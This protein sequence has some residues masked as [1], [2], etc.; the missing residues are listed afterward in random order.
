[1]KYITRSVWILSIVSLFTDMASEM[2]YP[3]MPIY[4]KSI[5]FSIVLIGI[6]EG[7]AEATAGLSKGYFGKRSDVAGRRVPFVQLG[8]AFSAISKPMMA[9]FVYPLWIFLARTVDRF[10]KGIRTGA[11]DALLS[12]EATPQTKGKVF[13]FHRSMDTLGA[14]IGPALALL[15]LYYNPEDYKT[16]FL[17]AFIPGLLAV[18]ATFF[19]KEKKHTAPKTNLKTTLFSFLYYWK[20]SPP[21]YRKLVTGLLLFSLF[22]SSDVFLLLQAKQSG[23]DDSMLI[24]VYI[25]YNLVFALF[26]FPVGILADK[27]GLKK[28]FVF[29]LT[30]FALVYFGMAFNSNP[31][32]FFGLFL[33]Y[34]LYAAATEGISKAWIS[35]ISSKEDTATAIGTFSGL[36]SICTMLA[37]SLTGLIWYQFGSTAAFLATAIATL[38]VIVY[39]FNVPGEGSRKVDKLTG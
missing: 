28:I 38:L 20:E 22:N 30:L 6:L 37:S 27:L 39:F 15:Y 4:L 26:A 25:F 21:T 10:G 17:I 5:G 23:M 3:I 18:L 16:L 9:V 19:L 24:G 7:I 31:Y 32:I 13:G 11:R 14:V 8:Y 2:L 33:L 12:D 34:G 35:N 29:G 36:Q 1:M